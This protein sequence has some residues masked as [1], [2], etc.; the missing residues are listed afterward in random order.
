M[1]CLPGAVPMWT[2]TLKVRPRW[3]SCFRFFMLG[4]LGFSGDCLFL[5]H[6]ICLT[7]TG[8]CDDY[9]Y[10]MADICIATPRWGNLILPAK[11]QI[12]SEKDTA[13][14]GFF[15]TNSVIFLWQFR[16][17]F[18]NNHYLCKKIS[19]ASAIRASS[20]ALGLHYLCIKI[21]LGA[22]RKSM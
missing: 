1:P 8:F 16:S 19:C 9:A 10:A 7:V 2:W 20:I 13:C 15:P 21:T 12:K 5:G 22:N 3:V 4:Y 14:Y 18:I 11:L 6:T 17:F